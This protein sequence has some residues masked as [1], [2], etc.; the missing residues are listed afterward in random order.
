MAVITLAV[1]ALSLSVSVVTAWLTLLRRGTVKMTQPTQVFFGPSDARHPGEH[2]LSK[3][4]LRTL[5][6]ATSKRGRV[7]ENMYVV[8]IRDTAARH[9][10]NIWVYGERHQLVRGSGLFVGDAGIAANHHF[11][12]APDRSQFSFLSGRYRLQVFARL[13]GDRR[14]KEMF[15]QELDISPEMA[16]SLSVPDTGVYFDWAPDSA[17]YVPYIDRLESPDRQPSDPAD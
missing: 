9:H 8:L 3:V 17:S 10:F 6:F 15:V 16:A 11:L 2:P 1:A 14:D 12:S 5:L 13:L 4:Y 7:V